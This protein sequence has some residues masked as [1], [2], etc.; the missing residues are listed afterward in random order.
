MIDS[1]DVND[2]GKRPISLQK[3]L[4]LICEANL[5]RNPKITFREWGRDQQFEKP[6]S[7]PG[8]SNTRPTGCV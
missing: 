6:C 3:H 8:A 4:H 1:L 2:K 5:F 7:K